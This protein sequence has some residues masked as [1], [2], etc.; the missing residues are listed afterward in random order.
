MRPFIILVFLSLVACSSEDPSDHP[1]VSTDDVEGSSPDAASQ[2]TDG[3]SSPDTD[4]DVDAGPEDPQ[5]PNYDIASGPLEVGYARVLAPWR[6]GAKPGQV[7]TAAKPEIENAMA[8]FLSGILST[9]LNEEDPQVILEKTTEWSL[10]LLE[11]QTENTHPGEYSTWFEPGRGIEQPPDVKATVIR[12]GDLKV[13][14][15]RAD[16]YL[17]HEFLHRYVAELV[18]DDTGLS[19]EQIFLAGTHNHSAPQPSYPAPGV[20]SLADGFDPRHFVYLADKI[21][22]AIRHA[23]A[24]LQPARVRVQRSEYADVQFNIIGP[25]TINLAADDESDP[26][27][28]EVGYPRHYFDADLDLIYFDHAQPPHEPIALIFSLGMHPETLPTNHGLISG[29]FPL[30]TE[31][32]LRRH[33]GTPA[34]WLP[35][36]L[37]DIEPDQGRNNPD[38]QF[39]RESFDALHQLSTTLADGVAQAFEQMV[40]DPE[41]VADTEPIFRNISRDIYGTDDF[42]LPTTAYLAGLRVPSPRVLHGS[43]LIRLQAIRLGDALLLGLPAEITTD[44]SYNIKSRLGTGYDDVYQGYHFAENPAWVAE[45]IHQNFTTTRVPDGAAAPVP[46][47]TSVVGGYIGY[48]VSRWEYENRE[49]Y[50]MQLTPH[51]PG[52]ADHLAVHLVKL[53]DEMMGGDHRVFDAPPWIDED[54]RGVEASMAFLRTLPER[55]AALQADLPTLSDGE[56]GQ[57]LE[58]PHWL[59]ADTIEPDLATHGAVAFSWTGATR[60]APPPAVALI[61]DDDTPVTTGPNKAI[62]LFFEEPNHWVARWHPAYDPGEVD[63]DQPLRFHVSGT[64]RSADQGGQVDPIWDPQGADRDYEVTSDDFVLADL[65]DDQ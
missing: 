15:V 31:K 57:I 32:H 39:W 51:G 16:L 35:G 61:A 37:G 29:E 46:I 64:Y 30:H 43:T 10:E 19:R 58:P 33:L 45:R 54:L 25:R 8:E 55:V 6:V 13:A 47:V 40:E 9:L 59:E 7:G 38:H 28:I 41:I 62:H 26:E 60:D 52:T 17:M 4:V 2:D 50:R 22:E 5:P 12:R 65:L 27:P 49:H 23:N 24:N 36:A 48:V 18:E 63:G 56:L 42:P 1:D 53:V 34:M 20:W 14:V 11:E 21:A 44:L 3:I